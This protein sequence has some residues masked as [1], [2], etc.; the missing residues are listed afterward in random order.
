VIQGEL[1]DVLA[2]LM[3]AHAS[4]RLNGRRPPQS[5]GA[6]FFTAL[7]FELRVEEP[8]G[9]ERRA[10]TELH[11]VFS[12]EARGAVRLEDLAGRS[13]QQSHLIVALVGRDRDLAG[14]LRAF[15]GNAQLF[16][17]CVSRVL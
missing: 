7:R 12:K 6:L 1:E 4:P 3:T 15:V 11:S 14:D 8:Q 5:S 10:R 17:C 9:N 13:E 16:F 2:L